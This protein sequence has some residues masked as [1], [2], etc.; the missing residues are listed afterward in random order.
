MG[1]L[2]FSAYRFSFKVSGLGFRA[3]RVSGL[4]GRFQEFWFR[5]WESLQVSPSLQYVG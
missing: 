4:L 2:G 3:V 1:V 5:V